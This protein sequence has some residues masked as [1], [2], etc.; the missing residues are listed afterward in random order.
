MKNIVT[1]VSAIIGF[2]AVRTLGIYGLGAVLLTIPV[3]GY[4]A[5]YAMNRYSFR[6]SLNYE[7]IP[8]TGC[9]TAIEWLRN[10]ES[11]CLQLGF[12]KIDEFRLK[13]SH[14]L[15]T[16]VYVN[17]QYPLSF[18]D[19]VIETVRCCDLITR[20]DN[21]YSLTTSNGK[22][23]GSVPR[24]DEHLLQA[25]PSMGLEGLLDQHLQAVRFLT[26]RG[27]HIRPDQIENLRKRFLEQFL[28][29]GKKLT[30]PLSPIQIVYWLATN[31][32]E[33]HAKPIMEQ[34]LAKTVRLP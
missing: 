6:S 18:L 12:R 34:V 2:F 10:N 31:Y 28:E 24:P 9:E 23:G 4:V 8:A 29:D 33:R 20:F 13:L 27:F 14:P 5:L 32:K 26:Q 3:F 30:T 7:P 11:L 17:E 15:V 16:Y 21:G 25:F 22:N 1:I 19:Y